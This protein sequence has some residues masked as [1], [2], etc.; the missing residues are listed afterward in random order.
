M[1]EAS[2]AGLGPDPGIIT[3]TPGV[4]SGAAV[5]AGT[6]VPVSIL[7]NYLIE[8]APLEEFLDN[9]P[10][11]TQEHAINVIKL[12]FARTIGTRDNENFV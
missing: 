12:A 11:V 10:E 6:R 7:L 3:Q 2:I 4:V 8:G 9:Y 1:K 5:F